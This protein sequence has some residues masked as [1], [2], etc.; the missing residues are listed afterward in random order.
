VSDP[1]PVPPAGGF[2]VL[3]DADR[4]ANL[5]ATL[6]L[7]PDP[8][9]LWVFAYGSLM[10]R[11]AFEPAAEAWAA[12]PDHRRAFCF[13]TV[14]ARGTPERPGLGLGLLEAAGSRCTG[15]IQRVPRRGRDAALWALWQ[16][17]MY[18]GIYA[19]SWVEV[20]VDGGTRPVLAFVADPS[21]PQYA[22]PL[23]PEAQAAIIA[24]ATGK[25]GPCHEY[26]A[27]TVE[28]LEQLG[29]SEPELE[30]LLARVRRHLA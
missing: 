6:S 22:G 5:E 15:S 11:P 10:W 25:Y 21:H 1:H 20:A 14:V 27:R 7:A 28:S 30:A 29:V 3:S 24:R 2:P 4:R 17:E 23:E 18:S 13:W 9:D 26:L 12:L 19:P 8:D 16:R